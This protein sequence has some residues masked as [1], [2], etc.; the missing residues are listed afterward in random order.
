M[1]FKSLI[2]IV[3]ALGIEP[4]DLSRVKSRAI[5]YGDLQVGTV[6]SNLLL[7]LLP[8]L[9]PRRKWH[10]SDLDLGIPDLVQRV[11]G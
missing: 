3:G 4:K 8:P 1:R 11:S 10:Q 6:A 2:Q 9:R 5:P 7:A